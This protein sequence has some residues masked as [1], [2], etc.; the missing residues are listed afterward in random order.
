MFTGRRS[1]TRKE[2]TGIEQRRPVILES[3]DY[4]GV[5]SI[6]NSGIVNSAV[7]IKKDIEVTF[8]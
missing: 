3:M 8:S 6:M 2:I 7:I 1:T 4:H 5:L